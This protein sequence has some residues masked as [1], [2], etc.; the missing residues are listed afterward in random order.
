M[1]WSWS[2]WAHDSSNG[3]PGQ[4]ADKVVVIRSNLGL[5]REGVGTGFFISPTGRVLTAYHVIQDARDLTVTRPGVSYR[6]VSRLP[7][8]TP[9]A[10]PD[11]TTG[12]PLV[13]LFRVVV[14]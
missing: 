7:E 10:R 8:S 2:S 1:R 5:N 12:T 6:N 14:K 3:L 11:D 13:P 4:T 9:I